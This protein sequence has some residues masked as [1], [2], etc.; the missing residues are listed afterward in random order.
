MLDTLPTARRR[1]PNVWA[2]LAWAP[3][4]HA[5]TLKNHDVRNAMLEGRRRAAEGA[6]RRIL[7]RLGFQRP[8]PR[9]D[10]AGRMGL[11]ALHLLVH[12]HEDRT[13]QWLD[14]RTFLLHQHFDVLDH[15]AT[16]VDVENALGLG[17]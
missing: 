16:L 15:L 9:E 8:I 12:G 13:P 1:A 2:S 10:V 14:N 4:H 17:Q 3:K 6:A 11:E 7:S 5:A